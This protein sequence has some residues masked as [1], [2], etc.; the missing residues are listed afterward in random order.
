M[1]HPCSPLSSN[2][3]WLHVSKSWTR[4]CQENPVPSGFWVSIRARGGFP[5][6][7]VGKEPTCQCRRHKRCGFDTWV[8]KSSWRRKCQPTLVYL[9]GKSHGQRSVAGCSPWGH[10]ES[11]TTEWLTATTKVEGIGCLYEGNEMKKKNQW[12]NYWKKCWLPLR[13]YYFVLLY[14]NNCEIIFG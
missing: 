13:N 8:R 5:G 12:I 11:D 3:I 10:R 4:P 9:P 6:G 7:A 14:M 1:I 2:L